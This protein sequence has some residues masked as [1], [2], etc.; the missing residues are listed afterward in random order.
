MD[1]RFE[2]C[3]LF[4]AITV[5]LSLSLPGVAAETIFFG[6]DINHTASPGL[7]NAV[8]IAHPN[9]DAANAAFLSRLSGAATETFESFPAGS[10]VSTLTFGPDTAALSPALPVLN[11]PTG[12]FGGIYPISGNQ[13]LLQA[14]GTPQDVFTLTFST[15]QAAFGFYAT[16]IEIPGNLVLRFLSTDGTTTVDRRIPTPP[17]EA[18]NDTGSVAFWGVIDPTNPFIRIT[19]VRALNID[20]IGYDDMTAGRPE[21]VIPAPAAIMLG[22]IGAGLVGWLRRRR[23]L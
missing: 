22:S 4:S 20:G 12:T 17:V 3:F 7:E 19:F 2:R 15:P 11:L 10:S 23:T 5:L 14:S 16:D 21:A 1:L 6:E 8:R 18:T 13:T 9:S